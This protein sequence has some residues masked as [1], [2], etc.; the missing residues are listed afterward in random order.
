[1]CDIALHCLCCS[2]SPVIDR[3]TYVQTKSAGAT[4]TK[5]ARDGPAEGTPPKAAKPSERDRAGGRSVSDLPTVPEASPPLEDSDP[6][7]DA[8]AAACSPSRLDV[9]SDVMDAAAALVS[10]SSGGVHV[11]CAALP[12][13]SVHTILL[14]H[15]IRRDDTVFAA[16]PSLVRA[17]MSSP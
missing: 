6:M 9:P 5:R 12:P 16:L 8:G 3:M 4:P 15:A 2:L 14:V 17:L 13:N 1:M 11:S 7:S 10:A